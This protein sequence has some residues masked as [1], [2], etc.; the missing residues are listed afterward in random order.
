MSALRKRAYGLLAFFLAIVHNVFLIYHV[1]VYVYSY[2]V[3]K[4]SFWLGEIIFLL[5]NSINDPLFGYLSDVDLVS[6]N[7]KKCHAEDLVLR[8]LKSIRIYGPLLCISFFLFWTPVLP[9]WSHFVVGI[10]LY[11]SFLTVMDLNMN[12]LLAD[13]SSSMEERTALSKSR[14]LGNIVASISVFI[15][16][17]VWDQSSLQY[18]KIFCFCISIISGVG[19]FITSSILIS[20]FELKSSLSEISPRSSIL[21]SIKMPSLKPA[22]IVAALSYLCQLCSMKNFL[23]FVMM[24]LIQ[25]FHC[26]F[27]SSFMP[28]FVSLLLKDHFPSYFCPLLMGLSFL[29]PH[30]NNFY[31]L[32]LC[33]KQGTY[34]VIQ[35]LLV[36]K[37]LLAFAVYIADVNLLWLIA[38]FILSNRI[39]T[40]GICRLCDLVIADLID[41]DFVENERK[42]T[43]SAFFYGTAALLTKPGQSLAP[44]IGTVLLTVAAGSEDIRARTEQEALTQEDFKSY[45][46]VLTGV[47]MICSIVQIL[48]W[49]KFDLKGGKL[50]YIKSVRQKQELHSI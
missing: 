22:A 19:F 50:H 39:F 33:Q 2:K 11:D 12:S 4:A 23:Y 45:C 26:H 1:D 36:I 41:Q 29:L 32:R 40:E 44:I 14:S 3:D 16:Y 7:A 24:S 20:Q 37:F 27:N 5:W 8:R 21:G 15:S 9:V 49:K 46:L 30:L 6:E 28:L 34:H 47:P 43:A 17:A 31:F 10:C 42:V 25:V 38:I 35:G 48:I 18:F 13:I